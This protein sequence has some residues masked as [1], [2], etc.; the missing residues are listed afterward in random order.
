MGGKRRLD[1]ATVEKETGNIAGAIII[2][3]QV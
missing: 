2:I 3:T 1:L